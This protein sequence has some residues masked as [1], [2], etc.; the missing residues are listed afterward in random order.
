MSL[1][2][3][4]LLYP[5]HLA[6]LVSLH[7]VLATS[8][9]TR[10]A[11]RLGHLVFRPWFPRR[12]RSAPASSLSDDLADQR[13]SKLPRHLA[14]SL[15]SGGQGG[16]QRQRHVGILQN[17]LQW[18]RQ[19]GVTTL[20]VY[21]ETGYAEAL[22]FQIISK[23]DDIELEGM[24]TLAEPWVAAKSGV[25]TSPAGEGARTPRTAEE[26]ASADSSTTLVAEE[27]LCPS[28]LRLNLLSRAA[29][30]PR[31]ARLAQDL[32]V[33]V[34]NSGEELTTERVAEQVDGKSSSNRTET[35]QRRS[36]RSI[37]NLQL[38]RSANRISYS[39]SEVPTY[40]CM[41]S[42][43]GSSASPRCNQEEG[44]VGDSA[45]VVSVILQVNG[46]DDP[47]LATLYIRQRLHTKLEER[48]DEL[49]HMY[50]G[51]LRLQPGHH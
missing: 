13:W 10:L 23:E 19:L 14:V 48:R 3:Q 6:V 1:T 22:N 30:R 17:L 31:L 21:D 32:A 34:R 2:V 37:A 49:R 42:R 33:R 18:S 35:A 27:S 20:S 8:R 50:Q 40:V 28:H 16:E 26:D 45:V 47:P 4:R 39:S 24:V 36:P 5:L 15:V 46:P 38:S 51:I 12:R 29:G 7:A 9:A 43:P 44:K 41:D 25:A 11:F